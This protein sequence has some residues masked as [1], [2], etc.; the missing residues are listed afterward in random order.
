MSVVKQGSGVIKMRVEATQY[1]HL[2]PI[3]RQSR[4]KLSH[5]PAT[6]DLQ[7]RKTRTVPSKRGVYEV[8]S[9]LA[10]VRTT[11]LYLRTRARRFSTLAST[12]PIAALHQLQRSIP[13]RIPICPQEGARELVSKALCLHFYTFGKQRCALIPASHV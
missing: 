7:V 10:T 9:L 12:V 1:L 2:S 3:R 6:F 4:A 5:Q 11:Q 13:P 8:Y